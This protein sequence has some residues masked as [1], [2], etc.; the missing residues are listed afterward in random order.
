MPS[1][2]VIK[3]NGKN[4]TIIVSCLPTGFYK[5]NDCVTC[6]PTA[7][8]SPTETLIENKYADRFDDPSYYYGIGNSTVVG[9]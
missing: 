3:G 2:D 5:T 6:N 1:T 9:G 8:N 7:Y 4:G